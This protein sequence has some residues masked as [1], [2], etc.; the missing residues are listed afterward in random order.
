[1]DQDIVHSGRG[2]IS[3]DI[4]LFGR[5]LLF[6]TGLLAETYASLALALVQ[7]VGRSSESVK[8]IV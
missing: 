5:N 2:R 4:A 7:L 3:K 6:R 8:S 1:M